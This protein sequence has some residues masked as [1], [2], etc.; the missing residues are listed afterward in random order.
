MTVRAYELTLDQ[1]T[2]GD[3][4]IELPGIGLVHNGESFTV[5]MTKE[6]YDKLKGAYGVTLK[7]STLEE[8]DRYTIQA[9]AEKGI[10]LT[11]EE[12]LLPESEEVPTTEELQEEGGEA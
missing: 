5:S 8:S 10:D 12:V 3:V 7:K 4:D 6:E 11:P 9:A 2:A 1:P